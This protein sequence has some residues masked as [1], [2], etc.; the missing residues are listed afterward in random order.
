[1]AIDGSTNLGRT[2]LVFGHAELS[3]DAISFT[4]LKT[5]LNSSRSRYRWLVEV[6]EDLPDYVSTLCEA[7]PSIFTDAQLLQVRNLSRW[8]RRN[9]IV[10]EPF[11]IPNIILIPLVVISHIVQYLSYLESICPPNTEDEHTYASTQR[12]TETL[13]F[14]TGLLSAFAIS[15]SSNEVQLRKNVSVAIRLAMLIGAAADVQE[16]PDGYGSSQSFSVGWHSPDEQQYLTDE[17]AL[18]N[19]DEVSSNR[20]VVSAFISSI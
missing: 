5:I 16:R 20:R 8:I 1:M 2:L 11:C 9:D 6:L 17:L 19:N 13:G 18:I 14:C 7:E 10:T 12:H 15:T 4:Q 3:F